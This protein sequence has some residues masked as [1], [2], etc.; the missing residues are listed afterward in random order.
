MTYHY[1]TELVTALKQRWQ[2]LGDRLATPVLLWSG[3]AP[4]RNFPANHHPFRAS[5]HFLYFSG[6][7]LQDAVIHL[8]QGQLTLFTED[9]TPAEALQTAK[10]A[11]DG[12]DVRLGGGVAT[13][14]EFLDADLVDTMHI[15]VAPI[16]LGRGERLWNSPDELLD[17]F[18]LE[19]VPSPSGVIHHLFWRK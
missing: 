17:R 12:K 16:E 18:N 8:H 1:T 4:A 13:V 11:A 10:V 2:R 15:V 3:A 14:R 6:V 9:A 19:T 7:P 5:S